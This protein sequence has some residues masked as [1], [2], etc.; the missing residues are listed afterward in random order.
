[1]N[2]ARI[3]QGIV[4]RG[5]ME[6]FEPVQS[7]A[8][9]SLRANRKLL[10]CAVA[11]LLT[12]TS[13]SLFALT[14]V[15]NFNSNS[16]APTTN[17]FGTGSITSIFDAAAAWW[18]ASIL[19]S[20][21]LN[22]NYGWGPLGDLTAG[23]TTTNGSVRPSS[24][25]I[26]FDNDGSTQFFM[27]A[28]PYTAEEYSSYAD[29]VRDYAEGSAV[30]LVGTG[31]VFSGGTGNARKLD[32]FTLMAH[33]IGHALGFALSFS[34]PIEMETIVQSPLPKAGLNIVSLDSTH[35]SG[36]SNAAESFFEL[37]PEALMG[38]DHST[39]ATQQY[40]ERK[41]PSELDIVAIAQRAGFTQV[42]L[43]PQV[44]PVP[45]GLPLLASALALLGVYRRS[46]GRRAA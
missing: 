34:H 26:V 30:S 28:T 45:A 43:Q 19:D 44:V 12:A 42:D 14:I 17:V 18:E 22:I 1:M 21:V 16:T 11:G 7:R 38:I 23:Y 32:M 29:T 5:D 35:I 4:T 46:R 10:P 8:P 20:H 9:K 6:M 33:E 13:P 2:F 27:D 39:S 40:G 3:E 36:I 41:L 37:T 25:S 31:R 24:A 15:G